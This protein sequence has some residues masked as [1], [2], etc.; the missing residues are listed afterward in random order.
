MAPVAPIAAARSVDFA[1]SSARSRQ[2]AAQEP[3]DLGVDDQPIVAA[4]N[5]DRRDVGTDAAAEVH[6]VV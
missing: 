2:Q 5:G 1:G 4:P 3:I 6:D